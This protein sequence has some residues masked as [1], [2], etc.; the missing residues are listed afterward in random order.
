MQKTKLKNL[1]NVVQK[2]LVQLGCSHNWSTI[3]EA[4]DCGG[5][6]SARCAASGFASMCSDIQMRQLLTQF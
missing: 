6:K 5:V 4:K 2:Y 1:F 3:F